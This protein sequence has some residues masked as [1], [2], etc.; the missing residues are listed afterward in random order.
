MNTAVHCHNRTGSCE[1][2]LHLQTKQKLPTGFLKQLQLKSPCINRLFALPLALARQPAMASRVLN[3]WLIFVPGQNAKSFCD[4]RSITCKIK[5]A[6]RRCV[7]ENSGLQKTRLYE[8]FNKETWRI[9]IK[10]AVNHTET[11]TQTIVFANRLKKIK[12]I[13]TTAT[14]KLDNYQNGLDSSNLYA[15]L[16]LNSYWQRQLSNWLLQRARHFP[17]KSH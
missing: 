8:R 4:V 1:R 7:L 2:P 15:I 11:C 6:G 12:C 10:L 3:E 9:Y 14:E 13:Q 17:V 5:F 16:F